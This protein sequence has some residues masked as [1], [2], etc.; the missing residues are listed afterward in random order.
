MEF[1]NF[2]NDLDYIITII[3]TWEKPIPIPT[4]IKS[5]SSNRLII[6]IKLYQQNRLYNIK[7]L[8]NNKNSISLLFLLKAYKW[9]I[10]L[11]KRK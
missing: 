10:N 6:K 5:Q 1:N 2:N 11:H 4:A 9:G 8:L 7:V 3:Y